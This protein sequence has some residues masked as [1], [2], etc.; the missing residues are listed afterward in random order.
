MNLSAKISPLQLQYLNAPFS[1]AWQLLYTG[2]AK[3]IFMIRI[4]N[5]SD[6]SLLVSYDGA[7]IND[8]VPTTETIQIYFQANA[9]QNFISADM[10]QGQK[11][12][13]RSLGAGGSGV[14]ACT[15]YSSYR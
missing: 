4:I 2:F 15:G 1:G 11:V 6:T 3:P 7:T 12:W 9:Q 10:S 14:V 5:D 8:L 13:V